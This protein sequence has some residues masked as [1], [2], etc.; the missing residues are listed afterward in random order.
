MPPLGAAFG[1]STE[2]DLPSVKDLI[3][4]HNE[5]KQ[6]RSGLGQTTSSLKLLID[7]IALSNPDFNNLDRNSKRERRSSDSED[8]C[9]A[10][11]IN[12]WIWCTV[13]LSRGS[14]G[15]VRRQ[16]QYRQTQGQS[17]N[18]RRNSE[19]YR[20]RSSSP[21]SS[22]EGQSIPGQDPANSMATVHGDDDNILPPVVIHQTLDE[23]IRIN[24][25]GKLLHQKEFAQYYQASGLARSSRQTFMMNNI[26][27]NEMRM[28][29]I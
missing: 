12:T 1:S 6:L 25:D 13:T 11:S 29:N 23:S 20:R 17:A 22:D 24:V 7:Y 18:S 27:I 26:K 10:R 9:F 15:G 2:A 14:C 4:V 8:G 19:Q 3:D 28:R 5:N 21:A 16:Q